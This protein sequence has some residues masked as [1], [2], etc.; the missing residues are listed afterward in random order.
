MTNSSSSSKLYVSQEIENPVHS[1]SPF[2]PPKNLFPHQSVVLV[3]L[4]NLTPH[5]VVVAFLA[6]QSGEILPCSPTLVLSGDK[7]LN[8]EAHEEE[9]KEE[10]PLVWHRKGIPG[11]NASTIAVPYLE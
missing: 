2:L 10:T 1:I 4:A 5:T 9:A 3:R 7:S 11:A 8:F 6:I